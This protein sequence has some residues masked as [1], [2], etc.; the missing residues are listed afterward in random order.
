MK[1]LIRTWSDVEGQRR[2]LLICT[3]AAGP[4][5]GVKDLEE[6][7]PSAAS[8]SAQACCALGS[9]GYGE[10]FEPR[11]V[12]N[13]YSTPAYPDATM[14]RQ[15]LAPVEG[16]MAET[17][18]QKLHVA[19]VLEDDPGYLPQVYSEEGESGGTPSLSSLASLEQELPPDLLD[20]L[21]SKVTPFEEIYSESGVPS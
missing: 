7:P 9:W 15:L 16:R 20:S 2:A 13:V 4:T 18:N 10:L 21:G 11:G 5:Q 14:H 6:V 17:L 19:D 12:K 8:R 3:A 1:P